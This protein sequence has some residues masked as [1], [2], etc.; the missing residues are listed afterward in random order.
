MDWRPRHLSLGHDLEQGLG[1]APEVVAET[2]RR[3]AEVGLVGCTLEDSSGNQDSP[4]HEVPLAVERIAARCKGGT[5]AAIPVYAH[6]TSAQF[7]IPRSEPGRHHRLPSGL[8]NGRGRPGFSPGLLDLATIKAV[9]TAISKPF[10]FMVGIKGRSFSVSELAAAGV[11]RL[12]T[13]LYRAAMTG[14]LDAARKLKN[15]PVRFPRSVP[16]DP[17]TE[18]TDRDYD[19]DNTVYLLEFA[20]AG[21]GILLS[22]RHRSS[23]LGARADPLEQA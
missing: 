1:E 3:A 5:C 8:R 15:M 13:S 11:R 20:E 7:C 14:L 19:L 4:L 2:I 6:C 12:A 9:C 16:D 18:Q 21:C 22:I 10:N 17:G 23:G